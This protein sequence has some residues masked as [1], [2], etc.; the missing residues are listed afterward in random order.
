MTILIEN[1][2]DYDLNVDF[3]KQII[4]KVIEEEGINPN[5]EINVFIV[6][7]ED[8]QD[9]NKT[10]RGI[11]KVTD[12]LSFPMIDFINGEKIPERAFY[13]LGDIVISID[14]ALEQ[15]IDYGHT[16][17]RELGFLLIHGALHLLGYDHDTEKNQTTMF[18]KQDSLLK[19]LLLFR[20]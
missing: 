19:D 20:D 5:C 7:R 18:N 17:E 15:A 16:I 3:A 1:E 2:T 9:I 8:M 6:S 4:T 12:V 10:Q 11:D 13:L 14:V